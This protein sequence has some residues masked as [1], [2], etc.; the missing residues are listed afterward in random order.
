MV[1]I[2]NQAGS[3]VEEQKLQKVAQRFLDYYNLSSLSVSL[4]FLKSEEMRKI[5]QTYRGINKTTDVLSFLASSEEK[6][7]DNFLGEILF[8]Y[9]QIRKQAKDLDR[10]EEEELIFILIHG[11]LHLLGYTDETPEEKQK[12]IKLG[13]ELTE[14][15]VK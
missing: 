8:D 13:N 2:N 11:L 14:K 5:N 3:Q 9:E 7:E 10:G 4:A 6:K 12:M 1:E 15:F